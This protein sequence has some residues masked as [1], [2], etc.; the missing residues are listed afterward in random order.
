[1]QTG[2]DDANAEVSQIKKYKVLWTVFK[3]RMRLISIWFLESLFSESLFHKTIRRGVDQRS[4]KRTNE[5]KISSENFLKTQKCAFKKKVFYQNI[6]LEHLRVLAMAA[7]NSQFW[8]S[9]G[10]ADN[11]VHYYF[12]RRLAKEKVHLRLQSF[13]IQ[14]TLASTYMVSI[15]YYCEFLALYQA[16]TSK[17]IRMIYNRNMLKKEKLLCGI[18]KFCW[19]KKSYAKFKRYPSYLKQG[20]F[21]FRHVTCHTC[22]LLKFF[23]P[24]L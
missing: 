10:A 20:L 17:S 8:S 1:M 12:P 4:S 9:L 14:Y 24:F 13:L 3:T 15:T 2:K 5:V 22:F 18:S 11:L 6:I 21:W 23:A 19:A 16:W 7:S